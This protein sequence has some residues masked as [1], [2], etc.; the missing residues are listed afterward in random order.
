[1]R[2]SL[3]LVKNKKIKNKKL[4]PEQLLANKKW[5]T[6]TKLIACKLL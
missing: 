4:R 1:M 5:M 6:L 2:P 3:F